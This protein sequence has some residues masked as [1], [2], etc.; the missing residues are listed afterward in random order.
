MNSSNLTGPFETAVDFILDVES[1]LVDD[2]S[3]PGGLTKFGISQR[4]YP[5]LNIRDLTIDGAK[6]LYRKDYWNLCSCDKLPA[7]I[8]VVLF[9]AA[10]NQGIGASIRM[11]QTSVNV[12]PDGVIGP[13]TISAVAAQTTPAIIAEMIARRSLAYA[14]SPLLGTDGLG[15]FRR[16]AKVHHFALRFADA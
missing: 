11:L 13:T 12:T 10:V 8:A 5:S 14:Q 9:D 4:A 6:A 15:W 2:P 1:G 3:D 16:L 7:G